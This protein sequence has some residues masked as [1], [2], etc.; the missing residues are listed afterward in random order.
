MYV[1]LLDWSMWSGTLLKQSINSKESFE[2]Q[3][4]AIAFSSL[5]YWT[6]LKSYFL[7]LNK[8]AL[9]PEGLAVARTETASNLV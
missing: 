6:Y 1:I 3:N 2:K 4:S 5:P 8:K 9:L 7:V